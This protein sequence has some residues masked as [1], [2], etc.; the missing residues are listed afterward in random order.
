MKLIIQRNSVCMFSSLCVTPPPH[1][2]MFTNHIKRQSENDTHNMCSLCQ[3][4]N[5]IWKKNCL[6]QWTTMHI[7]CILYIFL[8]SGPMCALCTFFISS[9][10]H[11]VAQKTYLVFWIFFHL[12]FHFHNSRQQSEPTW[13]RT[14]WK[15][16]FYQSFT[17]QWPTLKRRGCTAISV[18]FQF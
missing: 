13:Y 4:S 16:S 18:H 14:R 5:E 3:N 9:T 17:K 11:K 6:S 12:Q 15:F 10:F 7:W 8:K 2:I 1:L